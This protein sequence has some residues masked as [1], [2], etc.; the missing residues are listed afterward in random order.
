MKKQKKV[1]FLFVFIII[2]LLIYFI[3]FTNKVNVEREFINETTNYITEKLVFNSQRQDIYSLLFLPKLK[4][5]GK[6]KFPVVIV[7]PGAQGTKESRSF[8]ADI[9]SEIKYATLVLDQRGIGE[10]NRQVNSIQQDFNE[11]AKGRKDKVIQF[12][13]AQDVL[14]AVDAL[15]KVK[16]LIIRRS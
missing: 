12:L 1:V 10:T 8:Y 6:N 16:K 13:M 5:S 4:S 7:L 14:N 15:S 11:F 2:I 3:F 9:F